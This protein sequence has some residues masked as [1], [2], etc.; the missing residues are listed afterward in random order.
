MEYYITPA[1]NFSFDILF[2]RILTFVLTFK[3]SDLYIFL[4][5]TSDVLIFLSVFLSLVFLV[6]GIAIAFMHEKAEL[7]LI[8]EISTPPADPTPEKKSHI[9]EWQRI[10]DHL[11]SNNENDWRLAILEAD[12]LLEDMLDSIGAHGDTIGDK[13]KSL[14]EKAFPL[15]DQAWDAHRV[16]NQ[17]AHEGPEFILTD[18]E[19]RRVIGL[20]EAV[21]RAGLFIR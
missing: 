14:D 17:I 7:D 10:L 3:N 4:K 5:E 20:Y 8:K 18:R 12:I 9:K 2:T 1:T 15:L 11:G 21:L 13:L 19:A 6:A 16:R